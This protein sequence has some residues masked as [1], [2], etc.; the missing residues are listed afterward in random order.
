MDNNKHDKS[1]AALHAQIAPSQEP[2]T[3]TMIIDGKEEVMLSARGLMLFSFYAW[4]DDR[5]PNGKQFLKEYCRLLATRK[6]GGTAS[7]IFKALEAMSKDEGAAWMQHTFDQYMGD[8][9]IVG[10]FQGLKAN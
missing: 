2:M 6:Y 3:R 7:E 4:R 10:L 1:L 5:K 9:D 8:Y